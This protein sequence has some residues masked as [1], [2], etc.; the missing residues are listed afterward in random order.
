MNSKRVAEFQCD[1]ALAPVIAILRGVTPA[2]ILPVSEALADGGVRFIE[3]T[4]NSPEPLVSIRKAVECVAKRGV[5]IGAGTVL[6]ADEVDRVATA[7]GTYIISPNMDPAVIRRTKELG[8]IS[9]PGFFT[10]S[11]A[12]AAL[13][14]GADLLK[15]FPAGRLGAGYIKDLKAVLP[16]PVIAVGGIDGDNVRQYLSHGAVAVGVGASLYKADKSPADL[17]RDSMEFMARARG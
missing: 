14:A 2:T 5:H 3:V 1:L 7:G 11:E 4:L 12:F 9:I 15:C 13:A 6:S 17:S 10:A 8:L 16:A